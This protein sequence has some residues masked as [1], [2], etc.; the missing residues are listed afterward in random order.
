MCVSTG[1]HSS[2]EESENESSFGTSSGMLG[3][4][5]LESL[6]TIVTGVGLTA[7][8]ATGIVDVGPEMIVATG[9]VVG[10]MIGVGAAAAAAVC[11]GR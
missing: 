4:V 7:T 5:S 10:C 2:D 9:T 8:A 3:S 1:T 6:I 11:R